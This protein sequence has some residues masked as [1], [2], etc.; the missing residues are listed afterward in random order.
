MA[1][2]YR[3]RGNVQKLEHEKFHTNPRNNFADRVMERWNRLPI[4][5]VESPLLDTFCEPCCRELL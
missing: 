4:E 5:N 3:T 2:N 1:S